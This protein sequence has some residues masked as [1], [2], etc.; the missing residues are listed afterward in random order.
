MATKFKSQSPGV[1]ERNRL[2]RAK[3]DDIFKAI[4]LHHKPKVPKGTARAI[5]REAEREE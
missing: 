3:R 5:R 1:I 2:R 4:C